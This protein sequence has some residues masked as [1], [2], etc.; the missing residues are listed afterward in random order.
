M[1]KPFCTIIFLL[2]CTASYSQT[3]K[4]DGKTY[5]NYYQEV[6]RAEEAVVN[7]RYV[8]SI[9]QYQKTFAEY[10]YNNPIDCYVAAQVASYEKDTASSTHFLLKGI[11]FG[12]PVYTIINNP[13]LAGIFGSIN[14]R[15]V[16]SCLTVYEN[17]INKKARTETIA[18][19]KKEQYLIHNLPNGDKSYESDGH[20][21]NH[22]YRQTWDT[23]LQEITGLIKRYGFPSQKIIGTQNGEDSMKPI[24]PHSTY[25]L[26]IFIHHSNAWKDIGTILWAELLKGNITPQMYGIIYESSNGK[27][28]Y[29]DSALYFAARD[30]YYNRCEKIVKNN[31]K[32]IN[33]DRHNIGLCSYEVMKMKFASRHLYYKWRE[34][35]DRKPEPF[36][37]F[38]CD[39]SFQRKI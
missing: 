22:K 30:C 13:H 12:V 31:L 17:S 23:L 19:F 5:L 29:S 33:E 35:T 16:D 14:K 10:P 4:T 24:N 2:I 8:E 20:T 27:K 7:G 26:F 9:N 39:F 36:F 34:K 15:V 25:A 1:Y 11:R 37:D 3:V 28:E 18:F 32:K 21:L 38:Q 6:A